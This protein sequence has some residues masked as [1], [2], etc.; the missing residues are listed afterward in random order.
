MAAINTGRMTHQYEIGKDGDLVVFLIGM[1]V[2][3]WW[4]PDR[5]LP[6]FAA[7]PKMIRELSEDKESGLLGYRFVFH[8]RGPWLVQYWSS[9]DKLYAYAGAPGHR[10]AW[11]AYN[12]RS[13]KAAGAVGVW[14]ETFEVS[15]AESIY[16][17][18]PLQGLARATALRPVTGRS[19]SARQRIST[20]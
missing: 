3:A 12:R 19:N 6:V 1:T 17:S 18:T 5:W 4:R 8:P 16:V 2:N 13:R 11:A 15:R 9:L 14:H 20:D 7:M 10:P